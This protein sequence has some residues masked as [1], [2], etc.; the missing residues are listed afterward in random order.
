MH[1]I[2][3]V[4]GT[5]TANGDAEYMIDGA[6]VWAPTQTEAVARLY[7]R[8]I[9]AIASDYAAKTRCFAVIANAIAAGGRVRVGWDVPPLRYVEAAAEIGWI[10]RSHTRGRDV[11]LFVASDERNLNKLKARTDREYRQD[12]MATAQ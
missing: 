5:R 3:I 8:Q 7:S 9:D 2:K 10:A 6:R 11:W 4:K 1:T 12:G